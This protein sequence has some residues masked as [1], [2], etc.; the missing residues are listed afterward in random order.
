M[1]DDELEAELRELQ[2]RATEMFPAANRVPAEVSMVHARAVW[3]SAQL[4]DES[5]KRLE[6]TNQTPGHVHDVVDVSAWLT[7]RTRGTIL[8]K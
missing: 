8:P 3:K 1:S 6:E 2:K 5:S 4:Q 7:P